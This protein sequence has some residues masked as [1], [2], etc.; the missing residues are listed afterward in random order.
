MFS[1]E[2]AVALPENR[3]LKRKPGGISREPKGKAGAW[4]KAPVTRSTL[5]KGIAGRPSTEAE[6]EGWKQPEGNAEKRTV[7][8]EGERHREAH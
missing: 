1:F 4:E 8:N 6:T 3:N 7:G 2:G 5:G